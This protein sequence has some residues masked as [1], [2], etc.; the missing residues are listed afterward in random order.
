MPE[1]PITHLS[2]SQVSTY[3]T[4]PLRYKLQYVDFIAPAF[5]ASSL[6]FGQAIHEAVGAFYQQQLIGD[7]LR[8][9]EMLDVYRQAWLSQDGA[10]VRFFNGDNEESLTE[11][12]KQMLTVFHDSFD[13]GAQILGIEEFFE[14][15]LAK[16]VPPFQGYIDLIEQS[17]AGGITVVDLKTA[18]KKPS[19]SQ[20]HSN[21][22]LTAYAIGA[23]ALGFDPDQLTLRLDV[24][25][26]TKTPELVRYETTRT[27]LE[28]QRFVKL[29]NPRSNLGGVALLP[30]S[31]SLGI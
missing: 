21:L 9:D 22:Q 20:A 31:A 2:Y 7:S 10:A 8:P 30:Y 23:Q 26:K 27:E 14:V 11:K 15:R 4:C 1:G 12:A 28:R 16:D 5:T 3:L 29:R 6:V 25:T 13:L 19:S 17:P 24:L 18:S